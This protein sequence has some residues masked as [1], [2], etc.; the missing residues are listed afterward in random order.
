MSGSPRVVLHADMDAFFASVEQRDRPELRGR[1]VIVGGSVERGVVTAASYEARP[2]GVHSAMPMA[3]AVRR[4]PDAVVVR[5]DLAKYRRVSRDVQTIFASFT[6]LVE[7]LS[8]DEAFLDVTG[9]E[10]RFG[11]PL[12]IGHALKEAVRTRTGLVVSVGVAATKMVAKIASD[13]SKPDGLREVRPEENA[14]FLHPLPVERLWGVGPRTR[15]AL[16]QAGITTIGDLAAT[17]SARLLG[18]VGPVATHLKRLADGDD[19]RPVV[20]DRAAHSHGE[21]HTFPTDVDDDATIRDAIIAHA[22]AVARRLRRDGIDA[23]TVTLKVKLARRLGGGRYPLFSRRF[24]LPSP[25]DD[26]AALADAALSLWTAHAPGEPIRLIGVSASNLTDAHEGDQLG[27]F[28]EPARSKRRRLNVALDAL[29]D[30]FGTGTVRRG[31]VR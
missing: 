28:D 5:G 18:L 4:C 25:T 6:P 29:D 13:V 9:C 30:R 7:P 17:S 20:A 3:L 8:L 19:D 31:P 23:R 21:E 15:S 14:T 22:E 11:A 26:G 1:P 27:L 12:A 16:A 2:F 24:T 10:R